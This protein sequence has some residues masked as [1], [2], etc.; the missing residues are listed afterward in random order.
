MTHTI[1]GAFRPR[2]PFDRL[3]AALAILFL[4]AAA[5]LSAQP[6]S[7]DMPRLAVV[8][9]STEGVDASTGRVVAERILSYIGESDRYSLIERGNI[10]ALMAEHSF[11]SSDLVSDATRAAEFGKILGVRYIVTGSVIEDTFFGNTFISARLIDVNTASIVRNKSVESTSR[12]RLRQDLRDLAQQLVAAEDLVPA[13]TPEPV[14]PRYT[15][16]PP[17]STP[18]PP[19][20]DR[21]APSGGPRTLTLPGGV[22]MRLVWVPAGTFDMGSPGH[23]QGRFD[24]E[25]PQ[26]RVTLTRGFW[27][28][29]TETTQEQW[30]A[31]MGSNPSKRRG[32]SLPVE[33]VSWRDAMSFCE[34]L[35]RLANCYPTLPTEAQW[36]YACRA[37]STAR[38][39]FGDSESALGS[40]AWY[41]EN[42]GGTSP[43]QNQKKS[44][45][46]FPSLPS[47]N[48]GNRSLNNT[49]SGESHAP[50]LKTANN[51]GLY[52]MHGNVR[53]WCLDGWKD[54][55]GGQQRDW[56]NMDQGEPM[57]TIRGGSYRQ[58]VK[59]Q[60]CAYRGR[61]AVER[62]EEDLGFR[63]AIGG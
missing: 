6:S 51:W 38:F 28:A 16:E 50:R 55:T 32:P 43:S 15:P 54:Y 34:R 17:R 60:R 31:V 20:I 9:F 47:F 27:L 2:S 24:D 62:Q 18:A 59:L 30:Q 3:A 58:D 10:E 19:P 5:S 48:S 40:Y 52:D 57:R 11:Q 61:A 41:V 49:S 12:E 46:M 22:D 37:G 21:S 36:E 29:E 4:A 53:E 26:T 1:R 23:E 35:S 25:G 42:S 8:D 56:A 39:S 13:Y 33:N 14:A 63:V 44:R 45:G 7:G